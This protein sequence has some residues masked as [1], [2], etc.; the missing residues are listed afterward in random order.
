MSNPQMKDEQDDNQPKGPNLVLLFSLVGL[1]L[2]AAIAIAMMI[3][4]PFYLRR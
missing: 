3:V 1:A 2:A 4:Y